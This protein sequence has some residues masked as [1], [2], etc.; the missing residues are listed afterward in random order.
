MLSMASHPV[1]C[2]DLAAPSPS[3]FAATAADKPF[4]FSLTVFSAGIKRWDVCACAR[5]SCL[6]VDLGYIYIFFFLLYTLHSPEYLSSHSIAFLERSTETLG[7]S[8]TLNP[9][10]VKFSFS[11]THPPYSALW[12]KVTEDTQYLPQVELVKVKCLATSFEIPRPIVL[13]SRYRRFQTSRII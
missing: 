10:C 4:Y 3:P 9:L 5:A 11:L 2:L 8:A 6:P 13:C 7:F 12:R 1:I